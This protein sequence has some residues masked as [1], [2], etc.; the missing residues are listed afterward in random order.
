MDKVC[1][2]LHF[3]VTG[4]DRHAI[5]DSSWLRRTQPRWRSSYLR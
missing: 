5:P 3:A 4:Y 1:G 2:V